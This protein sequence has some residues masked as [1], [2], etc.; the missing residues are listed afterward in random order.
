VKPTAYVVTSG[1]YSDYGIC[2]IFSTREKAER[3]AKERGTDNPIEE[4]L[5]DEDDELISRAIFEVVMELTSGNVIDK[6]Q[7]NRLANP[8]ERNLET[9][10]VDLRDF[11]YGATGGKITVQSASFVSPDHAV[12]LA[13]E[14]RQN[15]LRE[16]SLP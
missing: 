9:R 16:H 1:E 5:I 13:A 6:G 7:S 8:N 15:Y 11:N 12:K 10:L 4:Y 3:Y 2:A 14:F